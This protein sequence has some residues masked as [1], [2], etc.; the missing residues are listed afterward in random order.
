MGLYIAKAALGRSDV[1]FVAISLQAE[2]LFDLWREMSNLANSCDDGSIGT[3]PSPHAGR[4]D[5]VMTCIVGMVAYL[6]APHAFKT[7]ICHS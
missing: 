7:V 1:D 2:Q 6:L 3:L 4:Q 5:D